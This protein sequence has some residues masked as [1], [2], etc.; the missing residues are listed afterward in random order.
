[1]QQIKLFSLRNKFKARHPNE[2]YRR[3]HLIHPVF[4]KRSVHEMD[5]V[6]KHDL[7]LHRITRHAL[8]HQMET[9]LKT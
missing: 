7:R 3:K 5:E 9:F 1:M 4:R 6:D 2:L 8:Y